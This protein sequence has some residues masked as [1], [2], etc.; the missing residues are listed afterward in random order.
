VSNLFGVVLG[1]LDFGEPTVLLA[2][3]VILVLFSFVVLLIKRYKRCPSNKVLVVYGKVGGGGASKCVHGGAAFIVPLF[4]DYDYLDLEP[5]QIEIPL[6]GALSIENIR[7]NVPSIF[8]VAI[9]T[10]PAVM[11]NAAIR[12]LGL[13]EQDIQAQARDI[14]FGQL[15]QVIASMRIEEINRDRDSFLD[16]VQ[17]SLEPELKKIGLVLINVNITDITD[18]SGYIEAIG[19]KA[20]ATAIQQ[21]EID[22]ADQEKKG[23]VGVANANREKEVQVAEAHKERDIGTKAADK[24]RLVQVA[25]LDKETK[26]GEQTAEFQRDSDIADAERHKRIRVADADAMAVEGENEAKAL[27]A[28]A[29]AKLQVE[30]AEAYQLGETRKRVAEA[31]VL[32]AQYMAQAKAAKAEAAKVEEEKKADLVAPAV[33]Q[34]A[35]IIVD[36]EA[37]AERRRIEAEGEAKAIFAKLE[38]E[39]RG[40]YEI[41]AKK[42][43]G[44]GEIVRACETPQAAFQMLMLEQL[45][46]LSENAAKAISNIKFDKVVVWDGA[47]GGGQGGSSTA[48]FLSSM[49]GSLPPMLHMM[50]DIGGVE[51][52]EFFGK[53]VDEAV[54]KKMSGDAT[55]GTT[56]KPGPKKGDA[57]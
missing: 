39:A 18:E 23:A 35:R 19:R 41:L 54:A 10:E 11:Q 12:L 32:E 7:V 40:Q 33:A 50:R 31:D 51:M 6:R 5:L 53:L 44:F 26:V 8:T 34:K 2:M 46:R 37:E 21:A 57:T 3:F 22:V 17:S 43:Q 47:G 20:A 14:I 55:D 28:K 56:S 15:R 45:E 4:Q 52:P 16:R 9:G 25:V 27:I 24:E 42:G 1:K 49:A 38:A 30:R 13:R 29:E 36:A 48:N